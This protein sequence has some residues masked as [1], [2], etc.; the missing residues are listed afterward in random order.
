MHSSDNSH[1]Q[2]LAENSFDLICRTDRD[3]VLQYVSPASTRIL[4]WAPDELVGRKILDFV[5]TEDLPLLHAAVI[6]AD[7]PGV[8][9]DS[10]TLRMRRKDH[11]FCW[12]EI[13]A[14]IVRDP[15]SGKGIGGAV[16][17]RDITDRKQLEDKLALLALTDDLTG[18]ANRRAFDMTLDAE[19]KRTLRDGSHMSL[20]L[21]DLDHFKQFNDNYGHQ[22]GDDCLR[23]VAQVVRNTVHRP[24]DLAAR[25]GGEEIAIILPYTHQ[26]GASEIAEAIRQAVVDLRIPHLGNPQQSSVVTASLGTATAFARQGATMKMPESLLMSA[27]TALY[28]AK[29]GGRNRVSSHILMAMQQMSA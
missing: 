27:D 7:L 15:D 1:F 9:A 18:L 2:F 10:T 8:V 20:I 11:T 24:S 6:R 22:F 25:Y 4:G 19:W 13:N 28:K 16:V 17:M 26:V 3:T 29:H 12:L 14:T 21:L 23:T 5:H